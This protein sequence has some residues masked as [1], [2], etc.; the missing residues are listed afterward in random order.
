MRSTFYNIFNVR[1]IR[2]DVFTMKR[3]S[4]RAI[5]RVTVLCL[6]L[7]V[8]LYIHHAVLSFQDK[9]IFASHDGVESWTR[10]QVQSGYFGNHNV[11]LST[12]LA[13]KTRQ[14]SDFLIILTKMGSTTLQILRQDKGGT[15]PQILDYNDYI[16]K[17]HVLWV[18]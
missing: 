7:A 10:L 14:I 11:F 1:N 5:K 15:Y 13:K 4:V 9:C 18:I 16:S 6:Y 3:V 17:A 12:R 8:T 2:C